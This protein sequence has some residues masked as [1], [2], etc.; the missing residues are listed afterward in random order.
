MSDDCQIFIPDSFLALYRDT[1]GRLTVP[2]A[3][4]RDRYEVCEDL[5]NH[6]VQHCQGLHVEIGVDE[7]EVLRRCHLG[8]CSPDAG[9]SEAEA[10]WVV[11]RLAELLN[12]PWPEFLPLPEGS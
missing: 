3:T 10:G 8:L 4:L 12:W 11:T 1:R 5:A 2:Q 7:Q 9:V 6:L